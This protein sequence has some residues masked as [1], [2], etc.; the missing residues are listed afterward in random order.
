MNPQ[1]S[2]IKKRKRLPISC[3][4]CRKR[5]IKCD[6]QKPLCGACKKNNVPVHLCIYDDSPWISSIVKEENLKNE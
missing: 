2:Q 1:H 3:T 4:T 5:K 6:R